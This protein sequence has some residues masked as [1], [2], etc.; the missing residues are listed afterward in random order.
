MEGYSLGRAIPQ[1]GQPLEE[2]NQ[3]LVMRSQ[4]SFCLEEAGHLHATGQATHGLVVF[5]LCLFGRINDCL[6]N[7]LRDEFRILLEELGIQF[8]ILEFTL[9]R[10]LDG[11][12]STASRNFDD[13][14]SIEVPSK[15]I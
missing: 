15:S 14:I 12:G 10:N 9:S 7:G 4:E 6:K 8:K 1:T 13:F 11:N 2:L 5:L 3:L